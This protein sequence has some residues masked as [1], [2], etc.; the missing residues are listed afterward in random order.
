MATVIRG[1]NETL[2]NM[3]KRFKRRVND[4]GI[5]NEVKK[6]EYYMSRS[7]KRAAKSAAAR[8]K[9]CYLKIEGG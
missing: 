9:N 3:L 4:D 2:E 5:M 1:E 6:R 7:Q 8:K